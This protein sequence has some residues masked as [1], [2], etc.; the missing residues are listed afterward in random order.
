M[1]LV[2]I[3]TGYVGLTT[4]LAFAKLGHQVVCVDKD[5]TKIAR[6]D[7]GET[8]FYEP[9]L[10]DLLREMQEKG[11][12][13]FTSDLAPVIP[14]AE[15]I[16]IAVGTPSA[17]TGEA[18]LSAVFGVADEIGGHLKREAVVVVKSTV[19][20]GTN[21][22]VIRRVREGMKEAGHGEYAELVHVA[23]VPEF[24]REGSAIDDFLNPDRVVIGAEDEVVHMVLD[25]LH[26]GV[27]APRVFTTVESAELT[28][29]AANA[30][31]ATKISF[32]NEIANI[33]ERTGANVEEIA[34]GIGLDKRIGPH[35][36]RAG[37]G[38]GG[39]CFPKDVSALHQ[40]SGQR[41][42][43][44][45]ML[46]SVIEANMHQRQIFFK[47][48]EKTLQILKGRRI[49]VWGLA[50]KNNTDDVRES[51]A[52]DLVQRLVARGVEVVAYDPKAMD[53]AKFE[54]SDQVTFSKTAM[55]AVEGAEALLVLTEWPEFK[56]V[57]FSTLRMRMLEPRIFDGRNLLYDL[58]LA[59]KG[60]EY[61]GVG[62]G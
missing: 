18:D 3:G 36:L 56:Q 49:A 2:M 5:V 31:L 40:L 46:S 34:K 41:G 52:I 13:V 33:A 43:H 22:E 27:N 48:V 4:G 44:F 15:I 1:K 25:R 28:K 21:K 58:D 29:Y 26:V 6:L 45:R 30:F 42:Y 38:Y 20:V 50:F 12:I 24:L 35:F 51:A 23:S 53:N 61:Y 57:S 7:L 9:G 17:P 32:I 8:P 60:F 37:I 10:P 14:E 47:K 59:Q 19:P 16:M 62:L 39:S 11:R 55:D 54:L